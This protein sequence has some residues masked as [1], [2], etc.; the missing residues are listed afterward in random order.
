MLHKKDGQKELT[1]VA[2]VFGMGIDQRGFGDFSDAFQSLDFGMGRVDH[3]AQLVHALHHF[4]PERGQGPVFVWTA[5]AHGLTAGTFHVYRTCHIK[6][7]ICE[8]LQS[9]QSF[10]RC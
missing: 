4:D 2:T 8:I 3:H 9:G 6:C 7:R 1:L 5:G 10:P